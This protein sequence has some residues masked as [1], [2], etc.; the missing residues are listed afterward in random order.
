MGADATVQVGD[1][2]F[3]PESVQVDPGNMVTWEWVGLVGNHSVTTRAGQVES[4][5]SDPGD[6]SPQHAPGSAPFVHV[7]NQVGEVRY[8]CKVHP[9][10]MNGTVTVGTPAPDTSP[11]S[12][13]SVA[14]RV[15]ARRVRVAFDLSEDATVT[16]RAASARRPRR[17][18]RSVRRQLAG[19]RHSLSFRRRGLPPGR[20]RVELTAED[21]AGNE[22]SILRR[23]FRIRPR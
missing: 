9:I 11:P 18:L 1:D 13:A 5:D 10:T 16:L 6:N 4:F 21:S 8:F 7:F 3:T 15:G 17:T 23:A 12:V 19:G 22:S 2:F 20:Y 14:V